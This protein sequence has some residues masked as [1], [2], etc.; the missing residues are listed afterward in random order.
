LQDLDP[1]ITTSALIEL[2]T[3]INAGG[4]P[5]P[6]LAG[7]N[8]ADLGTADEALDVRVARGAARVRADVLSPAAD[9]GNTAGAAGAPFTT[10][11]MIDE[12][13]RLG[14][15]VKPWTVNNLSTME[16]FHDWGVDGVITD[17]ESTAEC[18]YL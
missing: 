3:A 9:G 15:L 17:C 2:N 8:L 14:L 16:D 13:H 7:L 5:S 18:V 11:A 12:A 1:A 4:G 6:W 10:R